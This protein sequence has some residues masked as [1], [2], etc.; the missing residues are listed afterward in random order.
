MGAKGDRARRRWVTSPSHVRA[1]ALVAESA[2]APLARVRSPLDH[3]DMYCTY[4]PCDADKA[5]MRRSNMKS[6]AD[7]WAA[8][9][10]KLPF[11]S[12]PPDVTEPL[13]S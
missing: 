1:V 4:H 12:T 9:K 3:I 11:L 6:Q 7:P 8:L 5:T 13:A 10:S 2:A